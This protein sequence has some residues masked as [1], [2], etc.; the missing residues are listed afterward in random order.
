MTSPKHPK[1]KWEAALSAVLTG[2]A[3]DSPVL[4]RNSKKVQ[5]AM[6][7]AAT[8]DIDFLMRFKPPAENKYSNITETFQRMI[9][10]MALFKD[11][12]ACESNCTL[13]IF[14]KNNICCLT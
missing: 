1:L 4:K 8:R 11:R 9:Q 2:S 5:V 6:K 10:R 12:P 7:L 3:G 14:F 13:F